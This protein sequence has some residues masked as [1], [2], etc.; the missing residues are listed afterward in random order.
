[1]SWRYACIGLLALAM[2]TS[3]AFAQEQRTIT[4]TVKEAVTNEAVPGATVIVKEDPSIAAFTEP[5]GSFVLTGVPAG[6]VTLQLSS[7]SHKATEIAVPADQSEVRV[8]LALA[9]AEEIVIVGRAPQSFRQNLSNGASVVKADSL[10][11]VPQQTVDGALQGKIAGAN[12]QSNS[13]APG[14]GLQIKLRGVSTIEGRSAP[15]YVVDGVIVSDSS[16]ANGI[17]VV[18]GSAGGSNASNQDNPVNRIADINPNDIESIEILKGASAAALYGSKASNGVVIITTKRG[19][20]GK[21]KVSVAQRLG[22]SQISN[23]LGSRTFETLDEA[24]A[25]FGEQIGDSSMASLYGDGT[26]RDHEG[27][28]TQVKLASETSASLSGGTDTTKYLV[29]TS[30]KDEPGILKGTGYAKQ[31]AR[32]AV[33]QEL[34]SRLKLSVTSNLI[35]S[36]TSRGITN[37]D[38]NGVSHYMVLAATPSFLDL[39]PYED[40]NFPVNPFVPSLNNPLQM[41]ALMSDDE[42]VWRNIT[43][44]AANLKVW[45]NT[46]NNLSINAILGIDRYQQRNDLLFPRELHFEPID[47]GLAGTAIAATAESRNLNTGVSATHSYTPDSAAWRAVTT[48]GTYFDETK[49]NINRIFA[50]GLTA[51]L[52][53]VQA[54]A[55]IQT[56]Q[57]RQ[58]ERD[59]A[60]AVQEELLLLDER[61]TVLLALLADRSSVNGDPNQ[62]FYYPK[63]SGAY[64]VPTESLGLPQIELLRARFAYGETGNKPTYGVKFTNVPVGTSIDGAP[65]IGVGLRAGNP[66][67]KPERQREFEGGFDIA[68]F[69]G[70]GVIE[71]TLYQRTISDL[72]L[73]RRLAPSTGFTVQTANLGSMRN[74]GIELMLQVTPVRQN[75][76]QWLSRTIFSLNRSKILELDVPAFRTGGFGTSLGEFYI[77]EGESATQIRGNYIVDE[78][79]GELGIK[80]LGDTEPDF[81]MSFVNDFTFKGITLHTLLDWQKGSDVINLTRLLYDGGQ[82][83]SDYDIDPDADGNGVGARRLNAW[84]AGDTAQYIEDASFLK[85]REISLSYELPK[86]LIQSIGAMDSARLSISGR[87]LLTFTNYSGLDP[88]VSN[89]GNQPI[90]RNIDVAPYPPSR[91]FWFSIEAGF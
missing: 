15:L 66:D 37:N 9:Q 19:R 43:S 59:Q 20:A 51:G 25:A 73:N 2:G 58:L 27:Q 10:I 38:N 53:S 76:F 81:R 46:N 24:V 22:F 29:S 72:L 1:M 54:G 49:I 70:R 50:E 56:T 80:K 40:G 35:H 5:D 7:G 41:V 16:I 86:S 61:L 3:T 30:I 42:E 8:E 74:R 62:F 23:K 36:L 34:G 64:R 60:I 21:P 44:V 47:D 57:T 90:A 32:M 69:D 12:I 71:F 39:R 33:D 52:D 82:V 48:V 89:F 68:G 14:G 6:E 26:K 55:S 4:G 65:G 13:G 84:V 87:N 28:L 67:L 63:A 88:E 78:A 85:V 11:A 91:S 83:T 18:T 79:T 31:T 77:E 45:S 75:D 17:N